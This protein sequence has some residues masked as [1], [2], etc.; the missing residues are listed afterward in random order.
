[1]LSVMARRSHSFVAP[2]AV[3]W[4]LIALL[5]AGC[6]PKPS[7]SPPPALPEPPRRAGPDRVV[8]ISI[9]TLRADYVGC[10]GSRGARTANLDRLARRGVRF[11]TA[12]SPTPLTLPSHASLLTGL[13]PIHHGIHANAVFRLEEGIPTLAEAFRAGGFATAGFVASVVLD[14][15]YGLD[16]GFDH[17][18]DALGYRR[19]TPGSG[20]L[21]ERS[22]NEVVDAVIDWLEQAPERFFLWVHFYDPHGPV[23]P[24]QP[25]SNRF[26][27]PYDAEI[28]FS[29]A[30]LDRLLAG[31]ARR[32]QDTNL[33]VAVTS[34]HGESFGEH[35]ELS[36]GAFIYDA[37]MHVP[38]VLSGPPVAHLAGT[39]VERSVTNASLAPTLLAL[40]GIDPG[41]MPDVTLESL[42]ATN[43]AEPPIYLEAYF[44]YHTF[45][46]HAF[47]GLV[48]GPYKLIEGKQPELY[49]R[50]ADPD[51][52]R[53]LASA[54]PE[55]LA[56]LREALATLLADHP[57]LGWA[58]TR[59]VGSEERRMLESLGYLETDTGG[60]P[61]DPALPD[62]R[63]RI[64]D[65][66]R[67]LKAGELVGQAEIILKNLPQVA[68]QRRVREAE[69]RALREQARDLLAQV[70]AGNPSDPFA[71]SRLGNAELVLENYEEAVRVLERAL[72]L[73]PAGSV[74]H[75][76][77]GSALLGVGRV[78]EGLRELR[79][80]IDLEPAQP[81]FYMRLM[82]HYS[83]TGDLDQATH[84]LEAVAAHLHPNDPMATQVDAFRA[85]VELERSRAAGTPPAGR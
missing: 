55:R 37:S 72:A 22:A 31:L 77:L 52:V 29:D 43:P 75:H 59:K 79:T 25:W 15:T 12:I 5:G 4:A 17:Y 32:G 11:E 65:L 39:R 56:E 38:L 40:A 26:D 63:E 67:I 19:T 66:E 80:A 51:E 33:L 14:R 48:S 85:R 68:F 10:Y 69:A 49:D 60:D 6:A 20:G 78:E 70:T 8:L 82:R 74:T 62:A 84:W 64:G 71:L 18:D 73:N 27:D 3:V 76:N 34:D 50:S 42:L 36:H 45:R 41:A 21:A 9:D 13:D 2:A 83:E 28:A 53:D 35:G 16:R 7:K 1:M 44:P 58:G 24:P 57:P 47:R 23:D 81:R 61:F 30:Q 46:W 54:Q